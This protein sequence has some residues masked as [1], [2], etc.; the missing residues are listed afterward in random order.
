VL[1]WAEFSA[2][3]P[4]L[5]EAGRSLLYQFGV[6]LA[7]LSTVRKD[8]GPRVH[9][10]CPLLF[11][12]R[13][14]GFIIASPKAHDL[15]RDGR[16]AMHSFPCPDNEDA[17]YVTGAA[18]ERL[19]RDLREASGRL[20]WRE[21]PQIPRMP[22]FEEQRLFEFSIETAML[23]RTTGHGDPTPRHTIWNLRS[24]RG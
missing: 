17:F 10:M 1:S 15:A 3:R 13:L 7:F 8:G 12:G 4:D 2:A 19:D 20:F 16:Y 23:T 5:A 14:L 11:E 21:R 22:D 9:P 6:G 18:L 24:R